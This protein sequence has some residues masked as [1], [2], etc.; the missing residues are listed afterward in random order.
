M[1]EQRRL[2]DEYRNGYRDEER[3]TAGPLSADIIVRATKGQTGGGEP[4][5]VPFV[6]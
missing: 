6:S 3:E 4:N 5:P 2:W 1:I